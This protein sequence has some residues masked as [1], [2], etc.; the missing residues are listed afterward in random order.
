[1]IRRDDPV[2][3]D[4]P[5]RYLLIPQQEHARISYELA[6]AWGSDRVAPLVCPAD[7]PTHPLAAVRTEFLAAVLHHDD[8][9]AAWWENP[10][11]DPV[12][13][14]PYSFTEMAP[15]DA[16]RLW[17]ASIDIC[18][19]IGPLAGWVVASHFSW[20]QS[21]ADDD[22][23]EW[24]SW[25][26]EVDAERAPWLEEWLAQSDRHTKDLADQC[27]AWLQAFDWMSLWLC[28]K[29]PATNESA[30]AIEPLKVG[31]NDRLA[32]VVFTPDGRE[33][34]V[35]PWAFGGESVEVSCAAACWPDEADRSLDKAR[36]K[37]LAWRCVSSK[38][39]KRRL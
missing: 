7:E 32:E 36:R 29:C 1:M 26:A 24:E 37:A 13:N 39:L 35:K 31:A 8:G 6:A 14:R 12:H 27:L 2:G 17:R 23:A 28:C 16:Q 21:K 9:W 19:D 34:S 25:L 11:I 10:G 20:L 18:R 33:L 38:A 15:A 22:Y 4:P 30:V 5:Q 3:A